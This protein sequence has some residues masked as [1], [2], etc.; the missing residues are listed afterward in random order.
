[1]LRLF[2]ALSISVIVSTPALACSGPFGAQGQIIYNIDHQMMQFCNGTIW[3]GMGGGTDVTAASLDEMADVNAGSPGDGQILTWD[4]GTGRWIASDGSSSF[5]IPD[6]ASVCNAGTD[7]TIRYNSS[8]LQLCVNGTGW[9]DVAGSGVTNGKFV[10]GTDTNEAVY[11]LGNVGIGTNDPDQPL[12]VVGNTST[13]SI[14]VGST[15]GAAPP[16]NAPSTWQVVD[17]SGAC[18]ANSDGTIRYNSG[19]LQL[20]VNGTGWSDV[21]SVGMV[22]AQPNISFS[23]GGTLQVTLATG[24]PI[25]QNNTHDP[26]ATYGTLPDFLVGATGTDTVNGTPDGSAVT[27]T[28]SGGMALC[29]LLRHNVWAPVNDMTGWALKGTGGVEFTEFSP[30]INRIYERVFAPGSYTLDTFSAMYACSTSPV[31]G[32]GY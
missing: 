1:M 15:T 30:G 8:K 7:G 21:G 2:Y 5:Q 11:T 13:T 32:N 27:L 12:T 9:S 28:I 17:D 16:V 22:N 26:W 4:N 18:D 23:G 24:L 31:G 20:C 19:K 10:D 6:D 14:I 29:Y 3:V 25:Y